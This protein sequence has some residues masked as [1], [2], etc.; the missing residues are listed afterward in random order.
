MSKRKGAMTNKSNAK[1]K[2]GPKKV[3]NPFSTG[4]GGANFESEVQASF[5]ALMLTGGYAPCLRSRWPIVEIKLQGRVAGYE[6]DDL[7]VVMEN[8]SSKE[9]RRLLCQVKHSIAITKGSSLLGEV[10]KAAWN[11]YRNPAIFNKHS[12]AIALITGPI[13]ETDHHNVS[14][15]LDQAKH[16]KDAEE[17]F[18]NIQQTN[19]SP[20]KATEKLDALKHHLR[21]A[22][23]GVALSDEELFEFLKHFHLIGYDLDNMHGVVASLLHSHFS[24]FQ[25]NSPLETW[26]EIV[27]EVQAWNRNAGTITQSG[28]PKELVD[29]FAP[30]AVNQMPQALAQAHVK[31][32]AVVP[33]I[34]D[35]AFVGK[36]LLLGSWNEHVEADRDAVAGFLGLSYGQCLEKSRELLHISN[37]PF[38]V[39]DGVWKVDNK[40]ELMKSV[41][42]RLL[43]QDLDSFL[44]LAVTVLGEFDPI[45][46]LPPEERY[47]ASIHG[48]VVPHSS[49]LR[50][51]LAEGL[52]L[53]G[54]N[55]DDCS[56]CSLG[57][58]E[59]TALLAVRQLLS[60]ADWRKW[61]SLNRLLPS[62]AESAPKEFLSALEVSLRRSPCPFDELFS[63]ETEGITGRNYLTGVLWA[64]E[65]LAWDENLLV[66]VC[67]NLA[68]LASNDPGGQ[69]GNRPFNSL[70]T[71][72][73]PWYPQTLASFDKH[74]VTVKTLLN[75]YPEI[76]WKLILQLLP[77]SITTS[78]GSH[79][80]QWRQ[81]IPEGRILRPLVEEYRNCVKE[82]ALLAVLA[83]DHN[84]DRLSELIKYLRVI[85][86]PAFD[87][88]MDVLQSQPLLEMPESQR[89]PIWNALT[90]F[91]S[92]HR[93]FSEA[94]WALP[95]ET[96]I[97]ID[98]ISSKIIPTTPFFLHQ[99]LFSNRDVELYDEKENWNERQKNLLK[100][101]DEAITEIWQVRDINRLFDFAA[102]VK[103][104]H[105]VGFSLGSIVDSKIDDALLPAYLDS[106][107]KVKESVLD[108]YVRRRI[109]V[110]GWE[111]C[112]EVEKSTWTESQIVYFLFTLPFTQDVWQRAETWLGD[113]ISQYWSYVIA[114]PWEGEGDFSIAIEML[115]E[116][117]RPFAAID[118]VERMRHAEHSVDIG[119]CLRALKM[120]ASTNESL[121]RLDSYHVA[122]LI[123]FL[124]SNESVNQEELRSVE[125]SFLP[126]LEGHF[127]VTPKLMEAKL[128]EDPELFCSMIRMIF[129]SQNKDVTAQDITENMRRSAER[130]WRLLHDWK[131][132]PGIQPDGTFDSNKFNSW[133]DR[134]KKL[135]EASGHLN[136]AL[137][138]IGELMIY[139]PPDPDGLWMNRV[140]AKALN[141]RD[142]DYL[143]RGFVNG[144]Y[145]SRGVHYVDPTGKPERELA[146]ENR[147]KAEEIENAGFQRIAVTMRGIAD[148][149]NREADEVIYEHSIEKESHASN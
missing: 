95:E 42:S 106:K 33:E 74:L 103:L 130:A 133:L 55:P 49:E 6:T 86:E 88:L 109:M 122:Q 105:L 68:E 53:L 69:W 58:P 39:K 113:R 41:G 1:K 123:G 89:E 129:K 65:S 85:P 26:A 121:H 25:L 91:T 87:R 131:T 2:S 63:Q 18:F 80:P 143:R 71:I 101:R 115:L 60:E 147:R 134:V 45:F 13:S 22:N 90:I 56:N 37:S 126:L 125:W 16:T 73:L 139:S 28:L 107:D 114:K 141:E 124:Q 34:A 10:L 31:P 128:A 140:I 78:M 47:R 11:D 99:S 35:A 59:T 9:R 118:C 66:R 127:G 149:Y 145:N 21:A 38:S 17:F 3:S 136:V 137:L 57:K 40:F 50:K 54:N 111:W 24:Q 100:R 36:C 142:A 64:L 48:K 8:P 67:V 75:E 14:W 96:L 135:S 93:Q 97:R 144:T 12:D 32:I 119:L 76:A 27:R 62:I 120:A 43:D 4:G 20:S 30:K 110:G 81:V 46:E 108:A 132:I 117:N 116:H 77:G 29:T 102:L 104:P 70:V 7:I 61:G 19:F 146:A 138:Q 52:A 98:A 83:A 15:L 112:D 44:E 82:L 51:G 84:S 79:K 5:V 94:G 92:E 148:G 23:G 72:L